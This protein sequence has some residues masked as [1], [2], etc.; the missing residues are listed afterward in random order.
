MCRSVPGSRFVAAFRCMVFLA[1]GF[2]PN[3]SGYAKTRSTAEV[4]PIVITGQTAPVTGG[5]FSDLQSFRM[6]RWGRVAF[7]SSL[8]PVG[9]IDDT[10][11]EALWTDASGTL[12][13]VAREGDLAP[14]TPDGV[15]FI[16]FEDWKLN[17][18]GTVAF[19]AHWT[20]SGN[21]RNEGIWKTSPAGLE[22]VAR[23]DVPA[24]DFLP[25]TDIGG[26]Y[27]LRM[28]DAGDVAFGGVIG[29]AGGAGMGANWLS[30]NGSVETL[31]VE[32]MPAPGFP[33]GD[34]IHAPSTNFVVTDSGT[35]VIRSSAGPSFDTGLWR[36]ENGQL[37]LIVNPQ[38]APLG[39]P[40]AIDFDIGSFTASRHGE[41]AFNGRVWLDENTNAGGIWTEKDDEVSIVIKKGDQAAGAANGTTFS[42]L[43]ISAGPIINDRDDLLFDAIVDDGHGF[44]TL[45]RYG[46]WTRRNGEIELVIR[47]GDQPP[48]TPVGARFN[49]SSYG[50]RAALNNRGQILITSALGGVAPESDVGIW[51][52]DLLGTLQLIVREGDTLEVGEGD[53]RTVAVLGQS[54]I[55]DRGEVVFWASF[56]D[57]SAALLKS[58]RVAVLDGDYNL[59]GI[60]DAADYTTWRNEIGTDDRFADG[61]VDGVVDEHDYDVWKSNY[62]NTSLLLNSQLSILVPEPSARLLALLALLTPVSRMWSRLSWARRAGNSGTR[63]RRKFA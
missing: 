4:S 37:G 24:P 27:F 13:L 11:D 9:S 2:L 23:T 8:A 42:S 22:L 55:S 30:R 7:E 1:V 3:A 61:N 47:Q 21:D 20:G 58:T 6:N 14:D 18:G 45:N 35:V 57:A 52:T 17:A 40:N 33:P 54:E 53:F 10:N 60:V 43:G 41:I 19:H 46:L 25:Q 29:P 5:R 36:F 34:T 26:V 28:N 31:M 44:N 62:G 50:W 38:I 59:D 63:H 48:E 15:R 49:A 16:R 32:G 56:T 39:F 12:D 51:A